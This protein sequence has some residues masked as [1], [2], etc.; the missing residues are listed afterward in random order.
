MS[1]I[2]PVFTRKAQLI[3]VLVALVFVVPRIYCWAD[4][5]PLGRTLLLQNIVAALLIELAFHPYEAL[6]VVGPALACH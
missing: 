6:I 4:P 2:R 3:G 5:M 1:E